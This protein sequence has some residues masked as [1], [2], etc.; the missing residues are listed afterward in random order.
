MRAGAR[1][2]G[3][4][5]ITVAARRAARVTELAEA[6]EGLATPVHGVAF[7]DAVTV[8]ADLIVN[9]TPLG[10][11]RESLPLPPVGPQT[12]VVDLLYHPAVTP[13]QVRARS[14]G[15]VVFGGIGLLL[16]QA[17]LLFELWT[18]QQPPLEVMSGRRA[19]GDVRTRL[20]GPRATRPGR[21]S[22]HAIQRTSPFTSLLWVRCSS[23][24]HGPTM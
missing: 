17:A 20:D 9:A 18:G 3:A 8:P 6:L 11:A 19:R 21:P 2:R 7:D 5:S 13:L 12:L 1:P 22:R 24:R 15:A 23:V 14:E 16:H 10:V 4:S